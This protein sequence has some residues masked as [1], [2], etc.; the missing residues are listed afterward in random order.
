VTPPKLDSLTREQLVEE[1]RRFRKAET[2]C[3][4]M[5]VHVKHGGSI[6]WPGVRKPFEQWELSR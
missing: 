2:V 3:E 4:A 5:L 6:P 1:V